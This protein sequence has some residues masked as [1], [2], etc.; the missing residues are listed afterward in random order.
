M[1]RLPEL[2]RGSGRQGAELVPATA[3]YTAIRAELERA[4][5]DR[6][7]SLAA[8]TQ[9][10]E[11]R[12]AAGHP[13]AEPVAPRLAHGRIRIPLRVAVRTLHLVV[14]ALG[15]LLALGVGLV[16]VGSILGTW[17]LVPVLTGSM[18]PGIQPGDVVLVTPEPVAAVKP[19]QI[20]VFQPPGL[21]GVSVVHRVISV[22]DQGGRPVIRTKGD[23]NNVPDAWKAKLG[24]PKA[25]RVRAV[26]PKLGYL[27][28]AE[29]HS[30]FLLALKLALIAG[31]L[32]VGFSA[33]WRHRPD[34]D[35]DE[36]SSESVATC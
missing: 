6:A 28:V 23:A 12:P 36:Q 11:A 35:S 13:Q 18:R 1:P 25:W 29:K 21:G 7:A 14:C 24:G 3:D 26:I 32:A 17:G 20:L 15:A 30:M 4:A 2:G 5:A 19:G 22:T 10:A 9:D 8:L 27:A 31:G 16:A 34:G 33:I